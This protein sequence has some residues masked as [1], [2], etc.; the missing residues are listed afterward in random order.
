MKKN[1][2]RFVSS[3]RTSRSQLTYII[4]GTLLSFG[5]TTQALAYTT[6][7]SQLDLGERNVDVTSLQQFFSDNVQIYPERLT[8]GYF[9]TLTKTAVIRFQS[10]YGFDQVGRVG[11]VTRDKIN[12]L[13]LAG[14]WTGATPNTTYAGVSPSIY[15][16]YQS[17]TS[18]AATVSFNTNTVT[19]A[20]VVYY[21]NPLMFNEGDINSVGFGPIGGF[22]VN[23]VNGNSQSHSITVTGLQPNTT[24][25][26]TA[27]VTDANGNVSVWGPNSTLRTNS[28]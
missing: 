16:I 17:Q 18:N 5:I 6:I 3:I 19:S 4:L 14:G 7:N 12:E 2:L 25:Y 28:Q 10:L 1:V 22:S 20:R 15:N 13:I 27:I 8:T 11:P 24:Y 21:T 26:Y 23:S 9:G